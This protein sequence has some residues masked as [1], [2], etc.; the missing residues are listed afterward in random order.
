MVRI[1][2]AVS[3]NGSSARKRRRVRRAAAR[4]LW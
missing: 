4:R 1:T 2:A 3:R